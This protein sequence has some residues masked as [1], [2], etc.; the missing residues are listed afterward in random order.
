M[1]A[2]KENIKN[3]TGG[4]LLAVLL[5]GLAGCN[6]VQ[7][8]E[9]PVSST[10]SVTTT[11]PASTTE[12]PAPTAGAIETVNLKRASLNEAFLLDGDW[13]DKEQ[14][15]IEYIKNLDADRLLYWYYVQGGVE[16]PDTLKPYGDWESHS[17]LR[18][19]TLGHYLTACSM[20]YAQTGGEEW[21]L[22]KVNYCVEELEKCQQENGYLLSLSTSYFD[23]IEAGRSTGVPYYFVHKVMAGLLDAYKY[24]GNE[25]AL[26]MAKRLG[27]WV[28]NRMS[29]LTEVQV[30][31]LL[32]IEY[33]GIAEA[34]YDLYAVSKNDNHLAAARMFHES[35]Y[36]NAWADNTD[37]LTGIH[38]NTTIPK[39]TAFVKEYLVSGNEQCLAAAKNF[40]QMVVSD[41]TYSNGGN[42]W[43]EHFKE[44]GIIYECCDEKEDL[45][46]ETCNIYNMI[47][48]SQYLY[49]IT[50]EMKYVDYIERALLNGIMGSINDK[51]CKTY[52]QYLYL[53][54]RK[55]YHGKITG[56]WC[57]TG[58]GMENFAKVVE[59]IYHEQDENTVR[60][61][62]F[63]SSTYTDGTF[64]ADMVCEDEHTKITVTADG[65]KT[66]ALRV[67][68]WTENPTLKVNGEKV[69]I[70]VNAD[71]YVVLAREWKAGDT[72]E[73]DTP[74]KGWVIKAQDNEDMFSIMYGPYLM[75][76][77]GK[78]SSNEMAGSYT[79]G[80]LGTLTGK[81]T[82]NSE[83]EYILDTGSSQM[84]M[85]KYGMVNK[86]FF[87]VYFQRTDS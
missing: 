24:C 3:W 18:G 67:P 36:L 45:P 8:S 25:K 26:S 50:G 66:L 16:V 61:N 57:C 21:Y 56:F 76:A 32:G 52:Y 37:N 9:T 62:V 85:Q 28:Y 71:G 15:N 64:A 17:F 80:W 75:A 2:R 19:I 39:A 70:T 53:N 30:N 58:T 7:V 5:A 29:G 4:I 78:L 1:N 35:K 82:R 10:A 48:L 47:K 81:I 13:K 23:D 46:S 51:G 34:L 54:A 42:S 43:R 69:E 38:A 40:W 73:Y 86:G 65:S 68:Y 72:I 74:Y 87:T 41:H 27:D 79:E 55:V 33:G 77:T 83:G 12:W 44:P 60:Y 31:N 84:V 22:E 14:D 59:A 11:A 20:L 49:E 63:I 6:D